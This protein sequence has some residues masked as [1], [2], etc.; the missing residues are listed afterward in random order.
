MRRCGEKFFGVAV[1]NEV[2]EE[3]EGGEVANTS[4]LVDVMSDEDDG[5]FFAQIRDEFFNFGCSDGVQGT[6]WLVH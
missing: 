1:F 5:H 3:E 6:G 4:C 2:S